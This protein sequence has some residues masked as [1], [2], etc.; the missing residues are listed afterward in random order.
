MKLNPFSKALVVINI[1]LGLFLWFLFF[2]DYSLA[3]TIPDIL[4][5]PVVG[6]IA[7]VSL[8]IN[9]I[10]NKSQRLLILLSQLPSIVGGGLYI[11]IA[12]VM[13]IP[14]FTL[15][16]FF[17][18][19]EITGETQIQR[20]TSPDGTRSA[21]VYFRGVGAYSG[22]NGRIYVRVRHHI[23]PFLERDIFYLSKSFA[24]EDSTNYL[25]WR[26]NSTIYIPEIKREVSVGSIRAEIPQIFAIPIGIVRSL[27]AMADR[28]RVNQQ[29]TAPV[30][31]IPVYMDNIFDDQ[32]TYWEVD[33]TVFRSFN[34]QE[35]DVEKV[36]K[37]YEEVLSE[38][39]W[40][41][42]KVN[43]YT[44]RYSGDVY[45]E[46]CIQARR[47][48]DTEKRLYYWEFLGSN[49]LSIGVH[50]NIGTP[51]PI[52]DTCMRDFEAPR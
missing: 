23:L 26:D 32:S 34:I 21:Y 52:T 15:G 43:R 6:I 29:L 50:V 48:L 33:N 10:R 28:A 12:F 41:L 13:L 16:A 5:P 19:S 14:P 1:I 47:D 27:S 7:L 31:D 2:T 11:L 3:G 35:E 18:F 42:I 40:Q 25:E 20:V 24:N 46:Y 8:G 17:A 45:I 39:P 9:I 30:R 36:V 38:P 44:E 49:D 22:G 51:N 37:W 4:Y